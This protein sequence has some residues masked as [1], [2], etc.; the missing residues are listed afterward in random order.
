MTT[1]HYGATGDGLV[2]GYRAGVKLCFLHTVQYHPTGAVFPEQAEGLLITEKFRGA[3]ANVLNIDGEQFVN[4]REPRDV[5]SASFIRECAEIGKGIPTP[6]GKVGIWLDSPM[7]EILM[8]EGALKRE[9]PGKYILFKRFGIDISKEPMLVYPTLHY[10]NGGLEYNNRCETS[11]QGFFAAGEVSG[12]VH[13]ENRLMGNSLLDVCVF[14][15]IAGRSAASYVEERAKEGKLTLDHVRRYHKELEEA[16]IITDQ[17][18][19]M[20]LPDYSN[21]KVRERQLT[22]HYVGTIR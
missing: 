19:P 17:V 16:G 5:E 18:A 21:P 12:G 7:I 8:G 10:Q 9:F 6:T 15:R 3:G 22:A 20:I 13:G 14:G 11:I 1:N 2:M 4:E